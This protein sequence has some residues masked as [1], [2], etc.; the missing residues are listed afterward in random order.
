MRL[1]TCYFTWAFIALGAISQ[2][3]STALLR[4]ASAPADKPKPATA[5][6]A[7]D[8]AQAFADKAAARLRL[9]KGAAE[10]VLATPEVREDPVFSNALNKVSAQL[11]ESSTILKKWGSDYAHNADATEMAVTLAEH[12]A[13]YEVQSLKKQL[14]AAIEADQQEQLDE[15]KKLE[16]LSKKVASLRSKLD[17]LVVEEAHQKRQKAGTALLSDVW[18][19]PPRNATKA[20][21]GLFMHGTKMK[22]NAQQEDEEDEEHLQKIESRLASLETQLKEVRTAVADSHAAT[23]E[24]HQESQDLKA[25]T[26]KPIA[27]K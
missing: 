8:A 17:H 21:I 14:R 13:A 19:R 20:E 5:L 12:G 7:G 22:V 27:K 26:V 18:P 2:V 24:A 3:D 16:E 11:Q 4:Q 6:T 1:R 9:L 25:S 23:E 15:P 10:Q